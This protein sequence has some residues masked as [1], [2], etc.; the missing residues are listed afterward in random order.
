M[1]VPIG[2]EVYNENSG[3]RASYQ[4]ALDYILFFN[5]QGISFSRFINEIFDDS[6]FPQSTEVQKNVRHVTPWKKQLEDLFGVATNNGLTIREIKAILRFA[7]I[8]HANLCNNGHQ[9]DPRIVLAFTLLDHIFTED[10]K[11]WIT[12]FSTTNLID[13]NY[14]TSHFL[15]AVARNNDFVTFARSGWKQA[16]TELI[17]DGNFSIPI[18]TEPRFRDEQMKYL[19]SDFYLIPFGQKPPLKE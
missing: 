11:R 9:P 7:D 10:G 5:P 8:A 1:I 2:T 17:S 12:K 16:P 18:F 6:V 13:G 14:P 3:H 4:K 15:Q 19:L